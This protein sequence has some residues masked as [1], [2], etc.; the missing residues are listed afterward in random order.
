MTKV[1]NKDIT[2]HLPKG[3]FSPLGVL[4]NKSAFIQLNSTSSGGMTE[5]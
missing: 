2:P 1:I 4:L 5:L 3:M